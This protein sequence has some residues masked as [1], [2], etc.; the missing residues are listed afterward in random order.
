VNY[1]R[2]VE[3]IRENQT[4]LTHYSG[5]AQERWKH[6]TTE[7]V[8]YSI[9]RLWGAND[10]QLGHI[11]HAYEYA[12]VL[13]MQMFRDEKDVVAVANHLLRLSD[14]MD[15]RDKEIRKVLKAVK[16]WMKEY[17]PILNRIKSD[18]DIVGRVRKA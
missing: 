13:R 3:N 8:P 15:K 6:G 4:K 11:M 10:I 12:M 18:Q 14:R 7:A 5:I 2:L 1:E 9:R 17:Q 16:A